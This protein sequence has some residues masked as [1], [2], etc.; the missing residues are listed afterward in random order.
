MLRSP[1]NQRTTNLRHLKKPTSKNLENDRA[2]EGRDF[3]QLAHAF[4]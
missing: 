3:V 4:I 1:L 2:D